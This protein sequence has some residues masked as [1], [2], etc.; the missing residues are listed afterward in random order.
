[1]WIILILGIIGGSVTFGI[2]TVIAALWIYLG[3]KSQ[4]IALTNKRIIGKYGLIS[5]VIVDQPLSR[6]SSVTTEQSFFGRIFGFG[7]VGLKGMGGEVV[8]IPGISKP[9]EFRRQVSNNIG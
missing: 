4:Q 7:I 6:V 1:M 5:R 8:P 2:T 3:V 9:D